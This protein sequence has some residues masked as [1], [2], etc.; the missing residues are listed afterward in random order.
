MP[1]RF[2]LASLVDGRIMPVDVKEVVQLL[3]AR[4]GN[5][6]L[7]KVKTCRAIAALL[8]INS[9]VQAG[10]SGFGRSARLMMCAIG[11]HVFAVRRRE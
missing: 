11:V 8:Y 5:G 3:W 6:S 2:V 9:H 4:I 10:G 7:D 1:V